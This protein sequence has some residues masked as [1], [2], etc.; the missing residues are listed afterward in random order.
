MVSKSCL[1]L[2]EMFTRK[3]SVYFDL[4]QDTLA[5]QKLAFVEVINGNISKT[6]PR[7]HS[8]ILTVGYLLIHQQESIC[9]HEN[10]I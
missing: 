4:L 10:T 6:K 7:P 8:L 3:G 2:Q 1:V 5:V 9:I